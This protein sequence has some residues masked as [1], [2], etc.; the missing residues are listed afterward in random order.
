M[1]TPQI[2]SYQ[3]QLKS[4]KAEQQIPVTGEIMNYSTQGIRS[5]TDVYQ[6]NSSA[7]RLHSN[8]EERRVVPSIVQV[9]SG[10][11]SG[12]ITKCPH[13]NL[14]HF[15]KGMCNHCYHRYG[16]KGMVTSC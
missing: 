9:R 13:T 15:A 5:M 16:R 2:L 1:Y 4:V 11:K 10:R 12:I 3:M 8:D 14:K 6:S 7:I